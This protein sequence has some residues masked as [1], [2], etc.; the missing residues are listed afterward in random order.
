MLWIALHLPWLSLEAFAATLPGDARTAPLALVEAHRIREANAAARQL[1]VKPGLARATALALAPRLCLGQADARRDADALHAV[2]HAALA[3]TPAVVAPPLAGL[4]EGAAPEVLLEVQASLRCFGGREALLQKLLQVLAPLGHRI[5]VASAPTAL[6]AALL[7]RDGPPGPPRHCGHL[8]ALHA[9]LARLPVWRLGPGR[10]HW[11][12]LQGM[13]LRTLADLRTLPR[14]GLA[15]RFGE[16]LLDEIDRA[17]GDR[18]DPRPWLL[19]AHVFESRLELHARADHAEQLLHGA[20]VLL[21]RL[22]AWASAQQLR[23]CGLRLEMRHELRHRRRDPV[24]G[25]DADE[26]PPCTP[27]EIALAEP[28]ADAAHLAGLLRER[29]GRLR[30]PAPTLEL[31]LHATELVRSPPP[32]GELFPTPRNER[33]GLVRLIERLQAR[34]GP[35]GVRRL[36]PTPDHRPERACRSEPVTPATASVVPPGAASTPATASKGAAAAQPRAAAAARARPAPASSP[37]PQASVRRAKP[38]APAAAPEAAFG[39][40]PATNASRPVWLLPEPLRLRER[41]RV[42]WLDGAPLTLCSGPERIEAGWWDGHLAERDYFIARGA[43]GVL[44]WIFRS[45]RPGEAD[46]A[47]GWYLQG[48]FG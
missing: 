1:G 42:P 21:A 40:D 46:A 26:L 43:E 20:G 3:F 36:V 9:A 11:E 18:P 31:V 15:R 32:D 16:G 8:A 47:S 13:G 23:V 35:A 30:L 2:A 17:W 14:A 38:S 48:R 25:E 44:V 6:G 33:D 19:P 28:C 10:E 4:G 39:P 29:L 7:A 24:D 34:L 41:G 12:A 22:V 37:Q 45:R 5:A 27:L